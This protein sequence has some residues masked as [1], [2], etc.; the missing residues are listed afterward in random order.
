M[1]DYW[2]FLVKTA[3]EVSKWP[4]WKLGTTNVR[5]TPR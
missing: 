1:S 2:K 5:E 3:A 4:A